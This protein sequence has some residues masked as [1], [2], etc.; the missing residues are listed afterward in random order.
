MGVY[1]FR[2]SG[3]CVFWDESCLVGF[4]DLYNWSFST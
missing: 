1:N 2:G 4:W 3:V